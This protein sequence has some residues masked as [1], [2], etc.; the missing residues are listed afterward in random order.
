MGGRAGRWL[1]GAVVMAAAAFAIF[2]GGSRS[3]PVGRGTQAPGFRLPRLDAAGELALEELRGRVVLVNFWATWCKPCEDEMPA[4][5]RLYRRLQGSGFEVLAISVDE[6]A[7][8]VRR[9]RERLGLSFPILWDPE[10]EVSQTYQTF[11]YPESLL[12]GPD[13]VVV[14]R[15]IGEK[16]WDAETYVD[17]IRRLLAS[18]VPSGPA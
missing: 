2:S 17:R 14:E 5:E 15:Y 6:D 7:D 8:Q 18:E 4:M 12:V 10:R 13:G 16:D 3:A 11:R 9:F 1:V